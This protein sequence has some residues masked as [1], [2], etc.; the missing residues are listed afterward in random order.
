MR[1][2]GGSGDAYDYVGFL[3]LKRVKS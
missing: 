2:E 1:G 3:Q